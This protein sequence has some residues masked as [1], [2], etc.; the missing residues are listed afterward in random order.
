MSSPNSLIEHEAARAWRGDARFRPLT[1]YAY[2]LTKLR[3]LR[4]VDARVAR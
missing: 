1:I 4:G 2:A 3:S